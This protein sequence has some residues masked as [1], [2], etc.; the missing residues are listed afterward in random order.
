MRR[1]FTLYRRSRCLAAPRLKLET[2]LNP[3][4][5]TNN[6]ISISISPLLTS[7]PPKLRFFST[8]E[9][10]SSDPSSK[11]IADLNLAETK[12]DPSE[13]KPLNVDVED[14]NNKELKLRLDEYFKKGNEEALPSI[15]EAILKRKLTGKHEETDDE[16][17]DELQ[18][19]PL[20]DVKDTEFQSDL[21]ELETDEEIDDLYNARD[22][23][24]KKMASDEYF[25]MD[26]RKWDE[27]IKEATEKGFLKD[28]KEC[29]EILEDMLSWDKLLPDEI[30]KKVEE[31]FDEIAARVENGELEVEEGYALFKEFEDQMVMECAKMMEEEGPPQFDENVVPD[32]KMNLDD[33]PGEG[34]ILRWETRVVL[35]P[36]GDSWH[37]K[38]RKVKLSVT[39][40]ELGLSKHQFRRLRELVGKRYHPGR[41]ELT[42]TSERFEHREENRKDCLRTFFALIEE[43][44][45]ANKLV[46]D[47]RTSYLKD[48]LRSNP[49]FMARLQAKVMG[50]RES[51]PL[52]A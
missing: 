29:E 35:A 50:T 43:A 3:S 47:A 24:V 28:T 15:L 51:S 42:I 2:N 27:M 9:N 33:P 31:K 36:G 6:A 44:A 18:M 32:K 49:R 1:A 52:T 8:S 30:K 39:V 12:L 21:E 5:N 20:D 40:K 7:L 41:D 46:E 14:V 17:L 16:L 37:P 48:R 45:K 25:N 38:N 22:I 4:N 34:P 11:P 23:V 26:D 19:Q 13:N 10:E